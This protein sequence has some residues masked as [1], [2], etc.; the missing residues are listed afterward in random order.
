MPIYTVCWTLK[1]E[2][3]FSSKGRKSK[4]PQVV[5]YV[6]KHKTKVLTMGEELVHQIKVLTLQAW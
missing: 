1:N 3:V 2:S 5:K 4:A 6:Y